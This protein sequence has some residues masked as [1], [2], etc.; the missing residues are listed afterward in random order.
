M[1]L[2]SRRLIGS[3]SLHKSAKECLLSHSALKRVEGSGTPYA[4]HVKYGEIETLPNKKRTAIRKSVASTCS[5]QTNHKTAHRLVTGVQQYLYREGQNIPG[6][7]ME[8]A[9]SV[10]ARPHT[11]YLLSAVSLELAADFS[12]KF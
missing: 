12:S 6:S 1:I 8:L 10:T 9:S 3:L 4:G 2:L 7:W 5:R 11:P